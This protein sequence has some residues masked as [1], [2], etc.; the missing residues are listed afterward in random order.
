MRRL[1]PDRN[2]VPTL[3]DRHLD[4]GEGARHHPRKIQPLTPEPGFA[5]DTYR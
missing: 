5:F 2:E 3:I 4:E 1:V